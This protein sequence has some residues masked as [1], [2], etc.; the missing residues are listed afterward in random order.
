[1][2][3][4]RE[5]KD[6]EAIIKTSIPTDIRWIFDT[7]WLGRELHLTYNFRGEMI[8]LRSVLTLS[9]DSSDIRTIYDDML[10]WSNGDFLPIISDMSGQF[11][12]LRI[13]RDAVGEV[14]RTNNF[15]GH[16]DD[17]VTFLILG[18]N[19][20][21]WWSTLVAETEVGISD[22]HV[23]GKN[24]N[25]E[26]CVGLSEVRDL[27][28]PDSTG[29]TLLDYAASYGNRSV[30]DWCLGQKISGKHALSM[31]FFAENWDMVSYLIT[32]GFGLDRNNPNNPAGVPVA[33]LLWNLPSSERSR[34]AELLDRAEQNFYLRDKH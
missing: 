20:N 10:P 24:G 9:R 13:G 3:L 5:I 4:L 26:E 14:M 8:K 22:L 7:N 17:N 6:L 1:M 32:K 34:F 18:K 33:N 12:G 23:L 29:K 28:G 16:F 27:S 2:E 30:V 25:S 21:D 11:V 19:F 31:A 15:F